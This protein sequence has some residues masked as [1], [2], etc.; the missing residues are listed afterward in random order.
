[1]VVWIRRWSWWYENCGV[2]V[3][4]VRVGGVRVGGVRVGGVRMVV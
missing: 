3:G 4:G 2:R 1:M